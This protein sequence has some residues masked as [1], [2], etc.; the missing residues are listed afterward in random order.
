MH[1]EIITEKDNELID[2][3]DY[4]E[5]EFSVLKNDF[6][7]IQ[8]KNKVFINAFCYGNKLAYPI[9]IS[10]QKF[11]NSMDLLLVFDCGKSHYVYIQVFERYMFSITKTK[12]KI[13]F[14]I[15]FTWF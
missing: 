2:T 11:E 9:H 12:K 5:T 8:I 15:L 13:L 6:S 14:Q 4:S 10:D 1:S 3:L 7:K